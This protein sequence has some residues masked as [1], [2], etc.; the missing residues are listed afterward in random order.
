MTVQRW[1]KVS[2]CS[3]K[4]PARRCVG[5]IIRRAPGERRAPTTGPGAAVQVSPHVEPRCRVERLSS[6]E[7]L[8]VRALD[9]R[10]FQGSPR[11]RRSM[12]P[13]YLPVNPHVF[14]CLATWLQPASHIPTLTM[15]RSPLTPTRR[16]GDAT[17]T[18]G[19]RATAPTADGVCIVATYH[20]AGSAVQVGPHVEPRCHVER[21]ASV[22]RPTAGP[23]APSR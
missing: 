21:L 8:C 1:R 23:G 4:R 15:C 20:R 10:R 13:P 18:P 7:R 12:S 2:I 3:E 17:T 6:V 9:R 19:T 14:N 11:C 5:P 22:E 16:Q